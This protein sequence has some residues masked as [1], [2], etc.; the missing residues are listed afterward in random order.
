MTARD[1]LQRVA[2]DVFGWERLRPA[3]LQAMDAVLAGRDVLAVMATGSGKSAIYQVPGVLLEGITLVISPLI[4]LQR[5]QIS[6]LA[7]AGAPDAVA[8]NSLLG[9][10]ETDR[11]WTALRE[12]AA[13][14]VFLA[15]EQLDNDDVVAALTDAGI[16]LVVVDEAHCVSSWGHDFRP[17]Y[18]RIGDT[19]ERLGHPR[20]VALT[21]TASPLV[22]R[23]IV[24]QLRLREPLIVA[25]GFD[26]PNI[27]L[28]VSHHVDDDDKRAA[29]LAATL[30]AARPALLYTA[31]RADAEGYAAQLNSEEV[32]ALAYH[33]GLSRADRD[34]VHTR[35]RAG[36]VDVVTATSA[37]GMGIDKSDVR[38]VVHASIPDSVDNYYQQ[39]GRAGRDGQPAV[40]LLFYRPE[41]LG[42][43][44]FFASH[45]PD[46]A[47][48]AC[49]YS[50]VQS[51]P[52]P[53]TLADLH[54]DIDAPERRVT[55]VL[56]LLEQ[57]GL[58]RPTGAGFA[59]ARRTSLQDAVTSATAVVERLERIDRTR[60]EMMRGYAETRDCRRQFLLGYFGE[61]LEHPCGNCD[62]CDDAAGQPAPPPVDG[63]RWTVDEPVVHRQWGPGVV[64]SVE[65]DRITVLFDEY[66][67]RTLLLASIEESGVLR[68]SS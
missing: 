46:P 38:T 50:A 16:S 48:L 43:G 10:D 1:D 35:F 18:L 61:T 40:A 22:R 9:G 28:E 17:S 53:L 64:M 25:S 26:R 55:N 20:V 15:P 52:G 7:A 11:A 57:A 12:R 47:L 37:F 33:A 63:T 6:G 30:A 32:Q 19:V 29:A 14:Y 45:N 68:V 42:L 49:V 2:R 58:V 34:A 4:A 21:A 60:V 54:A 31:T 65:D 8:I 24:E 59:V 13:E 39:I 5:D 3:Q 51:A 67:Y 41:D 66:G 44:R 36:E 56:N 62:R 27:R 23:E